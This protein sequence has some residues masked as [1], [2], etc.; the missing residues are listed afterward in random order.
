MDEEE[1]EEDEEEEVKIWLDWRK[2]ERVQAV[3]REETERASASRISLSF[4]RHNACCN[5]LEKCVYSRNPSY[6]EN[7][8]LRS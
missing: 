3:E 4:L 1:R 6:F 5:S 7:I 8:F 2:R